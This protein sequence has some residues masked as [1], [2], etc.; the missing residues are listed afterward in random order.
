MKVKSITLNKGIKMPKD[1]LDGMKEICEYVKRSES[2][3]LKLIRQEGFPAKK[4]L[5]EWMSSGAAIE[6]W[7]QELVEK[8]S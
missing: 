8:A 3:V 5:G 7:R 6:K 4:V 1:A 2:T